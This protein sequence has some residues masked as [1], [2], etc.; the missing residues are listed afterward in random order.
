M[1]IDLACF[2]VVFLFDLIV[3]RIVVPIDRIR[4]PTIRQPLVDRIGCLGS[5][6][7][8]ILLGIPDGFRIRWPTGSDRLTHPI[9]GH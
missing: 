8:K 2:G 5:L 6:G 3:G 7:L 4:N 1:Q 9:T